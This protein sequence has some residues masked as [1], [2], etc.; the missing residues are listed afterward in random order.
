AF[1]VIAAMLAS[2][3]VTSDGDGTRFSIGPGG[4]KFEVDKSLDAAVEAGDMTADEAAAVSEKVKRALE[5]RKAAEGIDTTREAAEPGEFSAGSPG[6]ESDTGAEAEAQADADPD[7]EDDVININGKPWNRETNPFIIPGAPDFI[8]TWINDE[9]EDS[10]RKGREIEA[11]PDIIVDKIMDVLPISVFIML[12]LVALLLKFWYLFSGHYYIEHL[13]HALH[14]H[15]FLF[16][17]FLLMLLADA[18]ASFAEPSGKGA[19]T[20]FSGWADVVLACWIPVYLLIS[21][22]T[23]YQQGWTFTLLKFGLVGISYTA[24]LALVTS[25][26]AV[27]SFVLL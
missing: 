5:D 12:P 3:A 10:P 9:I 2:G 21:L 20:E 25:A 27:A 23:V 11:N 18:I 7:A 1:F 24:L 13:I 16:V 17:V 4:A 6:G 19:W 15:A 14:N 8:N 26:T 22:K